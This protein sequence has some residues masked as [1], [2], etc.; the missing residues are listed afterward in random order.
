MTSAPSNR[1]ATDGANPGE[2]YKKRMTASL[3]EEL[4][5]TADTLLDGRVRVLQP[6]RGHRIGHDA[7]LLAWATPARPGDR[8]LDLG[9]GVGAAAF[10]LAARVPVGY[11]TLVE[12]DPSLASLAETNAEANRLGDRTR[13][14]VADARARGR[15]R[16]ASGLIFGKIDRV[17]TNP[18][19]HDQAR[20][21][22]SP[23]PGKRL[24]HTGGPEL[25]ADFLR[26]AAAALRPSGTV[27]L[28]HRADAL[29]TVI[30][31]MAG[32]FGG[33]TLRPVHAKPDEPAVRILATGTKGS[34]APLSILPGVV[35]NG[36]EG[37]AIVRGR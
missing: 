23:H 7:V 18:P 10:C 33:V 37:E 13:V 6:R 26:T 29:E 9:A 11:L 4:D 20:G 36:L 3:L 17:M 5:I 22:A 2:R 19:F 30:A 31:T 12:I 28:I 34:R 8:V 27:T 21:R 1:K 32:R 25:L 35:L 16:E 24:A 15:A 14:I